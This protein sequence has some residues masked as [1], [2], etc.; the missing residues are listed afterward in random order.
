M[1]IKEA[2]PSDAATIAILVREANKDV[3][4]RFDFNS[5]NCPKHASFCTEDWIQADFERGVRYFIHA[6]HGKPVACVAY[7]QPEPGL[8]YLNRLAVLPAYRKRGIG[9]GLVQHIVSLTKSDAIYIISI[10][11]I[12]EHTHLLHWYEK[13]GFRVSETKRFPHLPFSVTYMTYD[14]EADR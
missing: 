10:G 14:V 9:A 7:E 1:S 8:A 3:A 11:I 13:L 12:G 4:V 2:A 5:E 6:E